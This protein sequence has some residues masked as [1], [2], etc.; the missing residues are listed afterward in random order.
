MKQNTDAYLD[1]QF[2]TF[3]E[4]EII[5]VLSIQIHELRNGH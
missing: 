4:Q 1:N 2:C 5:V 3:I